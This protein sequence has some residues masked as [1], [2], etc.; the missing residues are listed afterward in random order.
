[1]LAGAYLRAFPRAAP[2]D[3][4]AER[5]HTEVRAWLA[6]QSFRARIKLHAAGQLVLQDPTLTHVIV[7]KINAE[8]LTAARAALAAEKQ[9]YVEKPFPRRVGDFDALLRAAS[10]RNLLV[11]YGLEFYFS[12]DIHRLARVAREIGLFPTGL[13]LIWKDTLGHEQ[14]GSAKTI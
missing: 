12:A 8:H 3:L 13:R 11:Y 1:T 14:H 2:I 7:S 4:V 9:V 6:A 5:N 10:R